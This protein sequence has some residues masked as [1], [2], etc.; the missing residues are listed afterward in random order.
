MNKDPA[1][2]ITVTFDFAAL[3]TSAANPVVTCTVIAGVI[4]PAVT[5]MLAGPPQ[6]DGTAVLQRISNGLGGNIY[7][8]RCEI[9]D[10]DGERWVLADTL[11]VRIA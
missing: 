4:D 11:V 1:E 5:A 2:I 7:K 8:L 10:S 3:A 6:I 9:D